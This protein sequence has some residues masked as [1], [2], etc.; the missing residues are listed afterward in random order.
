MWLVSRPPYGG[1]G[2]ER[3]KNIKKKFHHIYMCTIKMVC[4]N[5]MYWMGVVQCCSIF[6][7]FIVFLVLKTFYQ[8]FQ[9]DRL[10]ACAMYFIVYF[11]E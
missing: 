8:L 4:L 3:V 6:H 2:V 9:V 7:A 11:S 1:Y 5:G 10:S